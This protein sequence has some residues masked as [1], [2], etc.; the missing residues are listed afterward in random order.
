MN[1]KASSWLMPFSKQGM[2]MFLEHPLYNMRTEGA[3]Y[4]SSRYVYY[5]DPQLCAA[6]HDWWQVVACYEYN[7]DQSRNLREERI[8]PLYHEPDDLAT[9]PPIK[10]PS[11]EAS[12]HFSSL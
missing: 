7:I 10:S 8:G 2:Q 12:T 3:I 5:Q 9:P 4:Y 1:F 11:S 6:G